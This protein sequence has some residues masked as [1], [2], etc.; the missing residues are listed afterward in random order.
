MEKKIIGL[1]RLQP[2]GAGF[3]QTTEPTA[4]LHV[5]GPLIP[6]PLHFPMLVLP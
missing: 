1:D 5:T 3:G 4:C 2:L 6:S